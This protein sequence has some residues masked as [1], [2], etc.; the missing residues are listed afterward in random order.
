MRTLM[1]TGPADGTIVEVPRG[2]TDWRCA[3][4]KPFDIK[5]F[6]AEPSPT[7]CMTF[8]EHR[9]MIYPVIAVLHGGIDAIGLHVTR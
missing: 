8:D 5:S 4:A 9:Y 6:S 1:V 3:T 7:E 2:R